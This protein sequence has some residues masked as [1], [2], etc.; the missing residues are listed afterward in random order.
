MFWKPLSDERAEN[1]LR[2]EGARRHAE[3]LEKDRINIERLRKLEKDLKREEATMILRHQWRW[4]KLFGI[5]I[6][7]IVAYFFGYANGALAGFENDQDSSSLST[8]R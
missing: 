1:I 4:Y 3:W 8:T 2:E 6:L 7:L 5:L